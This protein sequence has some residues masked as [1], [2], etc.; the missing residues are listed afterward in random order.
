LIL[1]LLMC[2]I[3][4]MYS[5]MEN[6]SYK[7]E[8]LYLEK[9]IGEG[10]SQREIAT[11]VDYSHS[12]VR[13]WLKKH[14]LKTKNNPLNKISSGSANYCKVCNKPSG[15]TLVMFRPLH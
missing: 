10:L 6:L 11:K 1:H 2:N 8:R 7:M 14:D 5:L 4:S 12:T 13:Y 9:L 15:E 3:S